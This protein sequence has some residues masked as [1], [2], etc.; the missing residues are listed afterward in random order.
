MKPR[1]SEPG[2]DRV[3]LDRAFS[4]WGQ[5]SRTDAIIEIRRGVVSVNGRA[6]L[7]PGCWVSLGQDRIVW[8]GRE[9]RP[10]NFIYLMLYKPPG[11]V[12]TY[13]DP[14]KRR[15]VYDLLTG[16][17]EWVFPIGRLDMDTS[18]LLLLTNDTR[19]SELLTNPSSKVPKTYL[20]K[21]NFHPSSEQLN[22]LAKGIRLKNGET[23][24]PAKVRALRYTEKCAFLEIIL[25]EGKNRQIRRMI[26]AQGGRVL[27]L[28]R[29]RIGNLPLGD[30][31]I[32]KYRSLRPRELA[33]VLHAAEEEYLT[34]L[35]F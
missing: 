16:Q 17:K 13:R 23:T 35:L 19:F 22:E 30:L 25:V 34:E 9:L 20:V 14:Q 21:V 28:V 32:G 3:T 11:V 18:G 1:H 2:K 27:K 29:T 15:T 5:L 7:D 12:T 6:V 31:S 24:L 26:E 4:K 33:R 10:R 8:E